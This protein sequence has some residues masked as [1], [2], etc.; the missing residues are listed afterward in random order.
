[1]IGEISI[2]NSEIK[3]NWIKNMSDIIIKGISPSY[4]EMINK[5][6]RQINMMN[7]LNLPTG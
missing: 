4:N 5:P 3:S 2:F 1:M 7:I 6:S